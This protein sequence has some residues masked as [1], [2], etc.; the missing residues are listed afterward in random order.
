MKKRKKER[1]EAEEALRKKALGY[2]TTEI[3]SEYG[4]TETGAV[5]LVKRRV[6]EKDVPPDL[7]A[8]KT[9]LEYRGNSE[10]FSECSVEEL[11]AERK[12]LLKELEKSSKKGD[13]NEN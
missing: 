8:L 12:K 13:Q 10:E 1:E 9:Y 2:K 5:E 3:V 7:T 4:V 6:T 11:I